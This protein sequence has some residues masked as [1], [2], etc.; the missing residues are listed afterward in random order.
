[1]VGIRTLGVGRPEFQRPA[2]ANNILRVLF[3]KT[4]KKVI[5]YIFSMLIICNVIDKRLLKL[6]N[7]KVNQT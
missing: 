4:S 1:M 6:V 5:N 3:N 2:G 7:S